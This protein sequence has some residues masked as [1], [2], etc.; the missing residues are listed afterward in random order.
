M[1]ELKTSL[2]K[3]V[4][5]AT[6]FTLIACVMISTLMLFIDLSDELLTYISFI[7]LAG[8]CFMSA[9][10]STQL[11]RTQGLM[12]GLLCG[13]IVFVSISFLSV[14]TG[15]FSLSA[16]IIIKL[17]VCIA[18]GALGGIKGIN[19]KHTKVHK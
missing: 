13:L 10:F 2:I 16:L 18:F 8:M 12:Q 9:Y 15:N 5:K 4:V 1:Y 7:L 11:K 3:G 6:A 14:L 17:F 19:T